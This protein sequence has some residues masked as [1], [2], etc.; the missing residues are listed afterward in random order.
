MA[1][2]PLYTG[3]ILD[4]EDQPRRDAQREEPCM[5]QYGER[6]SHRPA[7]DLSCSKLADHGS[8]R[9]QRLAAE[10]RREALPS[11]P[12]ALAVQRQH[13]VLGQHGQDPAVGG[14]CQV[15]AGWGMQDLV[16]E[17]GRP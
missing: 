11:L 13:R 3:L 4:A 8:D 1:L 7:L 16:R 2:E 6:R 17:L 12:V 14:A 5:W 9:L 15:G 10:H